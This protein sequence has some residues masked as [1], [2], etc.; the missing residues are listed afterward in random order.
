MSSSSCNRVGDS[1]ENGSEM[2]AATRIRRPCNFSFVTS[3]LAAPEKERSGRIREVAL[4]K[5]DRSGV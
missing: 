4:V 2:V 5:G 1:H 3:G